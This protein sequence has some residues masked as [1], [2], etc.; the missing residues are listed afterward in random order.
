MLRTMIAAVALSGAAVAGA[1]AIHLELPRVWYAFDN[2]NNVTVSGGSAN[3]TFT[4][5]GATF[6]K[7]TDVDWAITSVSGQC[8]YGTGFP[9]GDGSWTT[10]A[11]ARTVT[12]A[13]RI[14]LCISAITAGN[15]GIVMYT[16]GGD[17][18][19]FSVIEN[20]VNF[21]DTLEITVANAATAYHD[22]AITLNAEDRRV[23]VSVDGVACGSFAHPYYNKS[24]TSFQFFSMNGGLGDSGLVVGEG[25]AISDFRVYQRI[26]TAAELTALL[27]GRSPVAVYGGFLPNYDVTVWKNTQLKDIVR[28]RARTGGSSIGKEWA[29]PFYMTHS[30]TD[31]DVQMQYVQD[32]RYN[33]VMWAHFTQSGDDVVAKVLKSGY[34]EPSS[35]GN[36]GVLGTV[37]NDFGANWVNNQTIA[38]GNQTAGYGLYHLTADTLYDGNAAVWTA[39]DGIFSAAAS[40]KEGRTAEAGR[41]VS[42]VSGT[43]MASNDLA[44][45]TA[46]GRL[47]FGVESGSWTI[48]GNAASFAEVVNA[49]TATQTFNLPLSYEGDFS[50]ETLGTLVFS[51]LAVGGTFLPIGSG[52]IVFSGDAT[53]EKADLRY[54]VRTWDNPEGYPLPSTGWAASKGYEAVKKKQVH[55]LR[56]LPG[57]HATI[58][59]LQTT[60]T[61]QRMQATILDGDFTIRDAV[62]LGSDSIFAVKNGTTTLLSPFAPTGSLGVNAYLIVHEGAKLAMHSL[63][64]TTGTLILADGDVDCESMVSTGTLYLRRNGV[65]NTDRIVATTQ[66]DGVTVGP[67]GAHLAI[68]GATTITL[69]ASATTGVVFRTSTPAGAPA[70]IS[71]TGALT[72]NAEVPMTITGGGRFVYAHTDAFSGIAP[73]AVGE[74]TTADFSSCA[75]AHFTNTVALANGAV[76]KLPEWDGATS[77]F[78]VA[79]ALPAEGTAT[80]RI[81]PSALLEAGTFTLVD[82]GMDASALD[83]LAVSFTGPNAPLYG[84][85]LAVDGGALK[86]VVT[87]TPVAGP[88][89]ARITFSGYIGTTTLADFPALVKLPAGVPGFAYSDAAANG[90]DVY[91]T[92]A[93]GNRIA[94]EI[95]T[96][97]T[98]GASYLWVRV[99][100]LESASTY[101]TMHWGGGAENVPALSDKTFAGDY[102]GV[103]HFSEFDTS[104][105][106]ATANALTMTAAGTTSSLTLVDSPVGT[107]M[108]NAS[109]AARLTTPNS[110]K[111]LEYVNTKQLTISGW[112][113]T[114][115]KTANMRIVS[116][117]TTWTSAGGFE[118]TTRGSAATELLAGGANSAQYTKT[119]IANY[120]D[121][122]VHFAVIFDGTPET[123]VSRMYINGAL[124][125]SVSGADYLLQTIGNPLTFFSYGTATGGN[126]FL[127][128][129]DEMRLSKSVRSDDWI[130]AAYTT[131][132]DPAAFATAGAVETSV[133]TPY[134]FRPLTQPN[135]VNEDTGSYTVYAGVDTTLTHPGEGILVIEE[136]KKATVPGW[137][138]EIGNLGWIK[139]TDAGTVVEAP[140]SGVT[141]YAGDHALVFA[142]CARP[143]VF[144]GDVTVR[145]EYSIL[146]YEHAPVTITGGTTTFSGIVRIGER[147]AD[148][149]FGTNWGGILNVEG[150]LVKSDGSGTLDRSGYTDRVT[151]INVTGGRFTVPVRVWYSTNVETGQGHF[152]VNVGGTGVFAPDYLGQRNSGTIT[153]KTLLMNVNGGGVFQAPASVPSWTTVTSG[154]GTPVV[155]AAPGSTVEYAGDIVV[156]ASTT[157]TFAGDASAKPYFAMNCEIAGEGTVAIENA[158]FDAS[159]NLV[160]TNFTGGV[161]VRAGGVLILPAGEVAPFPITLEEGARVI[162]TVTETPDGTAAFLGALAAAPGSGTATI[163]FDMP[164][165]VPQGSV[166]TIS[167]SNLPAGAAGHLAVEFTGAAGETTSGTI[168][169]GEDGEVQVT[170]TGSENQGGSLVWAGAT[171]ETVTGDASVLAWTRL[172]GDETLLPFF[173]NLPLWFTDAASL[174]TVTVAESVK[175]GPV[176]INADADYTLRGS[177]KID[178]PIAVKEGNGTLVLDGG[179]F[180]NPTS[181]VLKAGVTRLGNSATFGMLGS[182]ETR[183]VVEDG[184]TLDLN[185]KLAGSGDTGRGA[186]LQNQTVVIK[187][188]GVDGRG[189][190]TDESELHQSIWHFQLGRIEVAA[191]ATIAGTSRIDLRKSS[192][193]TYAGNTSLTG[194]DEVTLTVKTHVDESVNCGLNLNNADVAIGKIVLAEGGMMG[195]EGATAMNVPK[196][197]EM[198]SGSRLHYWGATGRKAPVVVTGEGVGFKSSGADTNVQDAPVTVREGTSAD[199]RGDKVLTFSSA[200]TNEGAVTVSAATHKMTGTMAGEGSYSVLGGDFQV[201]PTAAENLNLEVSGGTAH[202]GAVADWSAVPMTLAMTGGTLWWGMGEEAGFPNATTPD[203][204]GVT[205]GTLTFHSGAANAVVPQALAAARPANMYF[206]NNGDGQ[207]TTL[208][209]GNWETSG[210]L[211]VGSGDYPSH[212]K[213]GDGASLTAATLQLATVNASPKDSVIEVGPGSTFTLTSGGT[214]GQWSGASSYNHEVIVNGGTFNCTA[215]TF[216]AAYDCPLC[217]LTLTDGLMNVK[218]INVRSRTSYIYDN[219]DERFTMT[220]GELDLGDGGLTSARMK[221]GNTHANLQG[222]L[223]KATANHSVGYY[224]MLVA[225]GEDM[226]NPG[227]LT[228]DLNGNTVTH[229]YTPHFGSSEVTITGEGSYVTSSDFQGIVNGKWT[230]DTA[231]NATVNLSGF[232]GFAAG[233]E[234]KEGTSAS[235]GISGEGLVEYVAL[236]GQGSSDAGYAYVTN[237]GA[238]PS[239]ASHLKMLTR[240]FGSN[241]APMNS[242]AFAVRGQFYVDED[243]AGTWTFAGN[244]DDQV[245][246]WMDGVRVFYNGSYNSVATAQTEVTAGWHDF[247]LVT[248]DG[249]GSQGPYVS[250]WKSSGMC[251]GWMK[252][253]STSTAAADYNRFDTSTLRMRTKRPITSD[254]SIVVERVAG[255]YG[256]LDQLRARTGWGL[257]WVTNSL[258]D[259]LNTKIAQQQAASMRYTGGFLV[260]EAHAGEW[261]LFGSVDD[262]IVVKF[263][264]KEVL[265]NSAW[266]KLAEGTTTV[267]PG[268]HTFEIRIGDGG[269]GYG[270]DAAGINN[271]YAFAVQRPGDAAKQPFDERTLTFTKKALVAQTAEKPGL[272]G[273]TTVAEGATLSNGSPWDGANLAGRFCPIYGTLE[274]G[275]TLSGPFRF[276]GEENVWRLGANQRAITDGVTF[277]NAD[278]LTL[279]GLKTIELAFSARPAV[280]KFV[281]G[282]ALGLTAE[283]AAEIAVKAPIPEELR[284][285]GDPEDG[286]EFSATVKDGKLVLVSAR[287]FFGTV[288]YM[289]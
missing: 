231:A 26:L 247:V 202:V 168:G 76:L 114:S 40:W 194:S 98:S 93:A 173:P 23:Y 185:T 94:H 60:L 164:N 209:A 75:S 69:G 30:A 2:T 1:E 77:F 256:D 17:K 8:P 149:G 267:K 193:A 175:S 153:Y 285:Q 255:N 14:V 190:I 108:D 53:I 131:M 136:G 91:F 212:L 80:I 109:N 213:L 266:N 7:V 205:G 286:F 132:K 200:F 280:T 262:R 230:V 54:N 236:R 180:V 42:F 248:Y 181:V 279:A 16:A 223:Y 79:P 253:A 183:V 51:D 64:A 18:V 122:W 150:G 218:G 239:V 41:N 162:A 119:G 33:K 19:R 24:Q 259:V 32:T 127:G 29:V 145:G 214:I 261:K 87:R 154:E 82:G 155:S 246:L 47:A 198:K 242:S 66:L 288:I 251:L 81:T 141:E 276:T 31:L 107:G 281:V 46:F 128:R 89:K 126:T 204:S 84:V 105:P 65:V 92:D 103:W 203:V 104:T 258:K 252:G 229:S 215:A 216:L 134:D 257:L 106:D 13:N 169:L 238:M 58:G 20:F 275:G 39:G 221:Y 117:K 99:P 74:G 158:I 28:V 273:T 37:A 191:D 142:E 110:S 137:N 78:D 282:D 86:A 49:S 115:S 148:Q 166:Y 35:Y 45:G 211:Y 83:H 271:G 176:T 274:G 63:N 217:Y 235:L 284:K 220:G 124:V 152:D 3:L 10:V 278:D 116:S 70:V 163:E 143:L 172:G 201:N 277:E 289:R 177:A 72:Q 21:E 227:E 186:V 207:T 287:P 34:L 157:L 170:I 130:K 264:D 36:Y 241:Q 27:D 210:T 15:H 206:Y 102:M 189:A 48:N 147:N 219:T 160:A 151:L 161:T 208:P 95:D 62:S 12:D 263:D 61:G 199:L 22:Y 165:S 244:F 195:L 6:E 96:W 283:T 121:N 249:T 144:S 270:T 250:D 222:G 243:D 4:N 59:F 232:A 245:A 188:E 25:C 138:G 140:R 228:I 125:Q 68:N 272:G 11:R 44:A 146:Q 129:I 71:Q 67:L 88:K 269:G 254:S 120:Y 156:P 178:A 240:S 118:V 100:Q 101:V 85:T 159:E 224:G 233:L 9:H 182:D 133:A 73:I 55:L 111:W 234:L 196:G 265:S 225:T 43:G 179:G 260:D 50:L 5:S 184:A 226:D 97:N 171:D 57:S 56:A 112:F 192:N 38:V 268:W 123:P 167:T 174:K 139:Y 237:N 113:K 197:V 90:A 187:G 135:T 52:D